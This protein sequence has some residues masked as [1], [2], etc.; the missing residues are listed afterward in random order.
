MSLNQHYN[1]GT[2]WINQS[3]YLALVAVNSK[4]LKQWVHALLVMEKLCRKVT[5]EELDTISN[6]LG[7]SWFRERCIEWLKV[8]FEHK[9]AIKTAIHNNHTKNFR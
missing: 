2:K 3:S 4:K 5:V 1:T 8:Q 9:V 7:K 6:R